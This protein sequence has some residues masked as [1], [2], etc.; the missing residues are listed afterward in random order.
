MT[1]VD[2]RPPPSLHTC[3]AAR[4]SANPLAPKTPASAH[5]AR[6]WPRQSRRRP[7]RHVREEKGR[8]RWRR[9]HNS[10]RNGC[11]SMRVDRDVG[12]AIKS[13]WQE[14]L[15]VI[16][17]KPVLDSSG[18]ARPFSPF[19]P[20]GRR[21][22][23]VSAIRA[24]ARL[25]CHRLRS[26]QVASQPSQNCL[27]S[28]HFKLC[29]SQRVSTSPYSFE[30]WCCVVREVCYHR[31]CHVRVPSLHARNAIRPTCPMRGLRAACCQTQAQSSHVHGDSRCP[32]GVSRLSGNAHQ[33]AEAFATTRCHE[34]PR[35]LPRNEVSPYGGGNWLKGPRSTTARARR[36]EDPSPPGFSGAK[37]HV[38]LPRNATGFSRTRRC[39][40]VNP[41]L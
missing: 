10:T 19:G 28:W 4:S 16:S 41:T 23:Q 25:G 35:T 24:W 33:A 13:C 22:R 36:F 29:L 21:A 11:G 2:T 8:G 3:A 32:S 31:F 17:T 39:Q 30:T 6:W 7:H 5:A 26:A 38:W 34:L 37:W 14:A 20:R 27:P 1:L 18:W 12:N 9:R 40:W 15:S